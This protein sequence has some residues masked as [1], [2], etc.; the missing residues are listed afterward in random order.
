M[1][2]S[3]ENM[4]Y[5]VFKSLHLCGILTVSFIMVQR[6]KQN[7]VWTTM[8]G[9]SVGEFKQAINADFSPDLGASDYVIEKWR[10]SAAASK[11]TQR[12][13]KKNKRAR[14][15]EKIERA[16]ETPVGNAFRCRGRPTTENCR[17]VVV[18][19]TGRQSQLFIVL[20]KNNPPLLLPSLL[21]RHRARTGSQTITC[22]SAS[23]SHRQRQDG[24]C[25]YIRGQSICNTWLQRVIIAL[26]AASPGLV[27]H[28]FEMVRGCYYDL[29]VTKCFAVQRATGEQDQKYHRGL[30]EEAGS[31]NVMYILS[32][33][34]WLMQLCVWTTQIYQEFH[35]TTTVCFYF[36]VKLKKCP[37]LQGYKYRYI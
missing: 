36:I 22:R 11:D 28:M 26:S 2:L 15:K 31:Q 24:W 14:L 32:S 17:R 19:E 37:S 8:L 21:Y 25:R 6:T 12:Q 1:P 30:G 34:R 18:M 33:V 20:Y 13:Q 9:C 35:V 16:S 5:L 10:W 27:K 7:W 4:L 23:C 3:C 29:G